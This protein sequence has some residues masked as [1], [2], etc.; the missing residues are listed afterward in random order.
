MQYQRDKCIIFFKEN[1]VRILCIQNFPIF[2]IF[3]NRK[4]TGD[5][6]WNYWRFS[7]VANDIPCTGSCW[8]PLTLW[9]RIP[10]V[11]GVLN[12]TLCDKVF[13]WQVVSSTYKTDHHD[14]TEILLKVVFNTIKPN[15]TIMY[16]A[17]L[18]YILFKV[19]YIVYIFRVLVVNLV[20]VF[21]NTYLAWFAETKNKK[22]LTLMEQELILHEATHETDAETHQTLSIP[23]GGA[24]TRTAINE[25]IISWQKLHWVNDEVIERNISHA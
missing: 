20:S 23:E 22:S 17:C 24:S 4:V 8:S 11:R 1:K 2:Y 6:S 16:K 19:I 21:W 13:Q 18:I 10:L 25:S 7:Q 5:D 9:V 14:I 15:H 12:T 3:D